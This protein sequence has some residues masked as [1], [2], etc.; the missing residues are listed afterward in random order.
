[1]LLTDLIKNAKKKTMYLFFTMTLKARNFFERLKIIFINAFILKHYNWN[2]NL[3]MKINA[4]NYKVEDVLNQKSKTDQWYFIVYYSY[5]FKKAEIQWNMYDKKL[6]VIVLDFKNWWYYFQS[7]KW[8]ICMITNYNNLYYFMMMKKFNVQQM[9][10]A[11]KLTVFDFHIKYHRDKFV[12][13]QHK[14]SHMNV[15]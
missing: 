6:Y 9:H 13:D 4:S 10:W 7:S 14:V 15:I 8:L 1:M 3:C 2:A 12:R 5:K 11:E